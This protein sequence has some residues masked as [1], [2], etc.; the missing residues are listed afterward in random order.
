MADF[1]SSSVPPADLEFHM[2]HNSTNGKWNWHLFYS[3][4]PSDICDKIA[5]L[6]PP[7]YDLKDFPCWNLTSD[8]YFSMKSAYK[9]MQKR[10]TSNFSHNLI[11]SKVWKWPSPG[12]IRA[13]L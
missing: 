8:G 5:S 11:F 10:N 4:V 2:F 7:N 1:L 12:R 3:I 13:Y 9:S 6:K